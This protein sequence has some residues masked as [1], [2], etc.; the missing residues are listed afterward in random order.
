[1]LVYSLLLIALVLGY[2]LYRFYFW[3]RRVK[4]HYVKLF[5]SMGYKVYELPFSFMGA[6][7]FEQMSRDFKN[8]QD[9]IYSLK[10]VY[11]GNDMVVGN[12]FG[13]PYIG[14]TNPELAKELTTMD[15]VMSL[16]KYTKVFQ[17]V[18]NFA[19]KSLLF[20]EKED[21]KHRRKLLSKTFSFEYLVSRIPDMKRIIGDMLDKHEN[22]FNLDNGK[23]KDNAEFVFDLNRLSTTMSSRVLMTLFLG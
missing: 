18:V 3:P 11:A 23:S 2:V 10:H 7:L 20:M 9:A 5:R 21:W 17:L 8:H 15:K 19:I 12:V 16:P 14:F 4:K 1:M 22:K 6:P 13:Y